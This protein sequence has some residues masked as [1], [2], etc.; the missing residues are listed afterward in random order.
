MLAEILGCS[1]GEWPIQYLGLPLGGN[2]RSRS[3]WEPVTRKVP[4][5]LDGWKT[6]FLSKEGRVTLIQYVLSTLP[7]YY[8]LAFRMPIVYRRKLKSLCEISYRR[9]SR[10][11]NQDI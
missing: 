5:R 3:F 8:M 4:K 7:T 9:T 6:A 1:V 11:N 10:G 2:P